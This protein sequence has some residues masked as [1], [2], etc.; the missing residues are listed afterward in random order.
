MPT[1]CLKLCHDPF[2][3]MGRGSMRCIQC[4]SVMGRITTSVMIWS[5]TPET[6]L[7][8]PTAYQ[9]DLSSEAHNAGTHA[10]VGY[11]YMICKE[12]ACTEIIE[13]THRLRTHSRR[14]I[15]EFS[16]ATATGIC[17][18]ELPWTS[19]VFQALMYIKTELLLR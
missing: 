8:T 3:M 15:H 2:P 9:T 10:T 1:L 13:L 18:R 14:L 5:R 16:L 11:Y 4:G 19:M 12:V 6:Y 7:H 17:N